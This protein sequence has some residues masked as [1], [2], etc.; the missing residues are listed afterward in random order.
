MCSGDILGNNGMGS[1]H[2]RRW[3]S[4]DIMFNCCVIM[5]KV[6][7]KES[8]GSNHRDGDDGPNE[9]PNDTVEEAR[10]QVLIKRIP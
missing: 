1:R 7:S 8:Q 9:D 2:R 10:S 4:G 3:R 5:L 6:E